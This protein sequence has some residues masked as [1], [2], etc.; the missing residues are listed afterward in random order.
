M[1]KRKLKGW[2]LGAL[3]LLLVAGLAAGCGG[4]DSDSSTAA[5]TGTSTSAD[6]GGAGRAVPK[7]TIGYLEVQGASPAAIRMNAELR[8]A[9]AVLGWD[10]NV[11]DSQGDPAKMASGAQGFVT[12]GV[13]AI[14]T[15]SV[16]PAAISQG[17]TA[18]KS[19]GIPAIQLGGPNL[20]PQRLYATT[21]APSD[22]EMTR[23]VTDAMIRDLGGRGDIVIQTFPANEATAIRDKTLKAMVAETDIRIAASH[24]V[25][26]SN[27][28]QDSR[29]SLIS[30]IRANPDTRA[31]WGDLD[32][33][34]ATGVQALN[35]LGK[36]DV[37]VYN[38][39]ANPDSLDALRR[40][41]PAAAVAESPVQNG[42]WIALD[43][44]LHFFTEDTPIA[45]DPFYA[46][47]FPVKLVTAANVPRTGDAYPW[48]DLEP[49]Y[50]KRWTDEG[51]A[52]NADAQ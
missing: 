15:Q 21:D 45:Q 25:D 5:S 49:A 16:A 20:D 27:P 8:R 37:K 26:L 10:V 24:D 14:I 18:A 1:R 23:V 12:Q 52:V 11:V 38:Y 41:G 36:R 46:D 28:I 30:M 48:P 22:E 6:A 51:Y 44:L 39:Y 43:Q 42:G 4:G 32:F 13:D 19:K 35:G 34:F 29:S 40:G 50:V 7:K 9:A 31:F 33:E 17:L 2:W 47:Q 3:M